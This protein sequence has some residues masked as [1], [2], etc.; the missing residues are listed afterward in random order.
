MTRLIDELVDGLEPAPS[1][2]AIAIF[3]LPLAVAALLPLA[4]IVFYYG[5][6]PDMGS[7]LMAMPFWIK[8]ALPAILVAAAG[9]ALAHLSR[10]GTPAGPGLVI[11]L[12]AMAIFALAGLASL[13]SLP[14]ETRL[15]VLFGQS[16]QKCLMS[17]GAFG[18]AF[19]AGGFW[20]LRR[21]APVRPHLA[22]FAL[23][24]VAGGLAA[25]LYS[26]ACNE[27]ALPF[28][29]SWYQLGILAVAGMS[30]LIAPRIARW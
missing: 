21:M 11:A 14:A 13:A 5:L 25:A 22:G 7:A 28:I 16:W 24:L 30:T 26:L 29:A 23:G 8:L 3:G 19:L 10:P 17:V 6:R 9:V 2:P 27:D 4:A 20:A 15:P 12:A 1:R 18:L